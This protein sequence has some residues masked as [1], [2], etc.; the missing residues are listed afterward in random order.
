MVARAA[1]ATLIADDLELQT[2][3]ET[4]GGPVLV[5]GANATDTPPQENLFVV[6][7]TDQHSKAFPGH[8]WYNVA[9]WVHLPRHLTRDY[10]RIDNFLL[11]VQELYTEAEQ[12][13]G[14][15]GWILTAATWMN[16]SGDNYDDGYKTIT[17]FSNYRVACRPV[18][19]P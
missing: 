15:D 11:R 13:A 9:V 1:L 10:G 6:L 18:V 8:G 2:I 5:Y 17:R 3:A 4:S 16:N 14:N 19:T 7:H 12:V